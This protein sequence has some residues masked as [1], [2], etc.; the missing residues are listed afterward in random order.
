MSKLLTSPEVLASIRDLAVQLH[1]NN[2]TRAESI[3]AEV[4]AY[5]KSAIKSEADSQSPDLQ[6][7]QQTMFAIDEVRTLLA[8]QDFDAAAAAARDAAKEWKQPLR[9]I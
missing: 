1:R 4:S 3:V 7:A 9:K 8:Q 5:L 2:G 6:R